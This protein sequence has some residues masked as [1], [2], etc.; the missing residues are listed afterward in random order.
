MVLFVT[1]DRERDKSV[2]L[3]LRVF[4]VRCC[5]DCLEIGVGDASS[6]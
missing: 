2:E 3:F 5:D 1:E 4:S 6:Q